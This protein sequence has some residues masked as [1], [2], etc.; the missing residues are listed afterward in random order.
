MNEKKSYE[1]YSNDITL[2]N[3]K[4]SV[5]IYWGCAYLF[6]KSKEGTCL[7]VIN[8][9]FSNFLYKQFSDAIH[10]LQN[11]IHT[12]RV[13]LTCVTI[14]CWSPVTLTGKKGLSFIKTFDYFSLTQSTII[15]IIFWDILMF[16]QISYSPQRKQCAI[17]LILAKNTWKAEIKLFP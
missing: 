17:F 1:E 6:R 4:C 11:S 8:L 13:L 5:Q 12:L 10:V 15:F 7:E 16:Y 3:L 2:E 9:A 14:S